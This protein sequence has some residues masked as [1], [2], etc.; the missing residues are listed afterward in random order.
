M[1]PRTVLELRRKQVLT[2]YRPDEWE[3]YLIEGDLLQKYPDLVDGLCFGFKIDLLN[4]SSTQTPPNR[5]SIS[6]NLD[7]FQKIITKEL[8]KGQYIECKGRP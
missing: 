4:I 1:K 3:F 8:A 6:E 2:P 7:T 5:V